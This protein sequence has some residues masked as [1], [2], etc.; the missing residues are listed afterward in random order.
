MGVLSY[1]SAGKESGWHFHD[2]DGLLTSQA[3]AIDASARPATSTAKYAVAAMIEGPWQFF[4]EESMQYRNGSNGKP[5]LLD[6]A[7]G[8]PTYAGSLSTGPVK[9]LSD[10]IIKIVGDPAYINANLGIAA[11]PTNYVPNASVTTNKV[12]KGTK[13]GDT[14]KP[15]TDL[16]QPQF[17]N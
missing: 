5:A 4:S 11:L 2:M 17:W 9:T 13:S 10:A 3:A 1:D 12:A 6:V 7:V 14:C 16:Y 8:T 15:K